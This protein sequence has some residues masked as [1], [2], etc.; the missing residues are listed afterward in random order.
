LLGL[1]F[2][3]AGFGAARFG[4]AFATLALAGLALGVIFAVLAAG[5]RAGLFPGAVFLAAS[6]GVGFVFL[7]LGMAAQS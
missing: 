3:R 6:L 7:T 2:E 4:A 1:G 5:V